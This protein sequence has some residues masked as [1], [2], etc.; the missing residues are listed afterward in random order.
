MLDYTNILIVLFTMQPSSAWAE[1]PF[2]FY[3]AETTA[4]GDYW[5]V[6]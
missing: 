3:V 5:Q 6:L 1:Q 2:S 4:P